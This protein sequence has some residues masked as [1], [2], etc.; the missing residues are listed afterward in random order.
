MHPGGPT[1]GLSTQ[2]SDWKALKKAC[3]QICDPEDDDL[4]IW[5][6]GPRKRATYVRERTLVS[7]NVLDSTRAWPAPPLP[8]G[9]ELP[10][11]VRFNSTPTSPWDITPWATTITAWIRWAGQR[12]F[13]QGL[14]VARACQRA[15]SVKSRSAVTDNSWKMVRLPLARFSL[16]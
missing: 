11:N 14:R 6:K 4:L 5:I 15:A 1:R 12:L 3:G 16:P 9:S 13:R 2:S 10:H 8:P 7:A